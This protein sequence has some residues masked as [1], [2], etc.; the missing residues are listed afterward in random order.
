M[1]LSPAQ[2]RSAALS[3]K[4]AWAGS[5]HADHDTHAHAYYDGYFDAV[6]TLLRL[7]RSR[8]PRPD[9]GRPSSGEAP[10]A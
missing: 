7:A 1:P 6:R 2:L 5:S 3:L 9:A 4:H 8:E 10:G